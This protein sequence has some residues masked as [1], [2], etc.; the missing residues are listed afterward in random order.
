MSEAIKV[1]IADDN[2]HQVLGLAEL[3]SY[4][5]EV[6]V[7][8]KATTAQ[9]AVALAIK[10]KPDVIMLDMI[11]YKNDQEGLQA[12][13]QIREG[14]PETRVLAMTAYDEV[15]EKAMQAGADRAIHKD[16]LSSKQ[17]VVDHI[18]ATYEARLLPAVG[19]SP[20]ERLSKRE[21]EALQW[22]C[23]GLPDKLIA[24]QMGIA[25]STAKKFVKSI[26][27]KL[28]VSNRAEAVSFAL[29]NGLVKPRPKK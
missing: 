27:M 3:L 6:Q 8:E 26:F 9:Q 13:R 29:G 28:S 15:I 2:I 4:S 11:W 17:A 25:P 22:M 20:F 5:D 23:E 18:K 7:I 12:I 14:A 10:L 19:Q 24:Q 1:L 21:Q 16:Y